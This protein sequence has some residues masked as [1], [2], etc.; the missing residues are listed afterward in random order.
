MGTEEAPNAVTVDKKI[1]TATVTEGDNDAAGSATNKE[2]TSSCF[3]DLTNTND[4]QV[5][6]LTSDRGL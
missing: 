6:L 5:N 1:D 3:G 4:S 2:M